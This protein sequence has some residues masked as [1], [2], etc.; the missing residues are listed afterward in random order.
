MAKSTKA[1]DLSPHERY[2]TECVA[3]AIGATWAPHD[4]NSQPAM[5]DVTLTHADGTP[6]ALEIS[7]AGDDTA[8]WLEKYCSEPKAAPG[9]YDWTVT[10]PAG[11]GLTPKILAKFLPAL[12]T[13]CEAAGVETPDAL[14]AVQNWL[15]GAGGPNAAGWY[16]AVRGHGLIMQRFTRP[17][18]RPQITFSLISGGNIDR[19]LRTLDAWMCG[20]VTEAWFASNV[21]KLVMSGFDELHLA[22]SLHDVAVPEDLLVSFMKAT[23]LD[24]SSALDAGPLT[25]LWLFAPFAPVFLHWT[26]GDGWALLDRP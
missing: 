26:K 23:G 2:I 4:D 14:P 25:D 1:K 7:R 24:S 22:V 11:L 20:Q 19:G 9:E 16:V 12:I 10:V 17:P 18:N 21:E 13:E 3:Q 6:A 15:P 5:Y 8:F